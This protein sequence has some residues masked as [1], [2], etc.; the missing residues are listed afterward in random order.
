MIQLATRLRLYQNN[1][2]T[3]SIYETTV[4]KSRIDVE[5]SEC[6]VDY[7]SGRVDC[8]GRVTVDLLVTCMSGRVDRRLGRW[9]LSWIGFQD[10]DP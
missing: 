9:C 5:S 2:P 10:V 7:G 3:V 4:I 8:A 1:E 6:G